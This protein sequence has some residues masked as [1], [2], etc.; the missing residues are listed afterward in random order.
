LLFDSLNKEGISYAVLRNYESLP[1]KPSEGGDID[2][3]IDK[4]DEDRCFS[5]LKK[6]VKKNGNFILLE[7]K[8]SS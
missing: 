8:Q 2:I 4:E 3:L 5:I 1:E 7:I 6:A